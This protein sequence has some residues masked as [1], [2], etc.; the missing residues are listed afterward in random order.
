MNECGPIKNY[1]MNKKY[2]LGQIRTL[3]ICFSADDDSY[4]A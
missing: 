1:M 2:F 3:H 4:K